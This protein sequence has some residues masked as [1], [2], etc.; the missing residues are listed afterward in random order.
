[1]D[2]ISFIIPTKKEKEKEKEKELNYNFSL[3]KLTSNIKTENI[4]NIGTPIKNNN[5]VN[6]YVKIAPNVYRFGNKN[7]DTNNISVLYGDACQVKNTNKYTSIEM[8]K[9]CH[10]LINNTTKKEVKY[11]ININLALLLS[12]TEG[13]SDE[14]YKYF[15]EA[16]LICP[17]RTEPYYYSSIYSNKIRNFEKS[18]DL[19]HKALLISYDVANSKYPGTQFTSYGKYLYDE[20]AVACYWLKKYEESKILLEK[21]INDPDFS[22]VNERI[23][24]NLE[25]TIKAMEMDK[26][27]K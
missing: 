4:S 14:I 8:F 3:P 2:K 13:Q 5:N 12:E 18:Y 1:M 19:L 10:E 27:I 17:D 15:D 20:L 11:E 7:H 9:K 16:L 24:T 25:F 22:K 21:I 26:L 23:K 6:D